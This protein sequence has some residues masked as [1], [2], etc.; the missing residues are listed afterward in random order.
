MLL[1]GFDPPPPYPEFCTFLPH[2]SESRFIFHTES[3]HPGEKGTVAASSFLW[4]VYFVPSLAQQNQSSRRCFSF[5]PLHTWQHFVRTFAGSIYSGIL[6]PLLI[7]GSFADE[8]S[9]LIM[10]EVGECRLKS[11][12]TRVNLAVNS[13]KFIKQ[14][15]KR[16]L[17]EIRVGKKVPF[18]TICCLPLLFLRR[19]GLICTN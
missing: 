7:C 14:G 11:V 6:I 2:R 8:Y 3:V 13:R 12:S 19:P 1:S 10:W 18:A 16:G 9:S 5:R 15:L 17:G 4:L